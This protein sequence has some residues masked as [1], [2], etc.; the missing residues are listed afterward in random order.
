MRHAAFLRG[1]NVGGRRATGEQLCAPFEALGFSHVSSFL[2]SGNI[3][4]DT[5]A[6]VDD[7]EPRIEEALATALGFPVEAFV[8]TVTEVAGV[9]GQQ[10][11][12]AEVA[13]GSAGKPQ[14]T[15]LREAPSPTGMTAAL[16]LAT[17]QDRVAVIGRE[18]FWLPSDGISS[19][20]LD[21]RAMERAIGRGTTRTRA[22]VD[23]LHARMLRD[24]PAF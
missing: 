1:I 22:T 20:S 15:F 10:P 3:A 7:L 19:S 24:P 2:A 14:V 17:D 9:V 16:E 8:R 4:F 12:A 18:W 13:A 21:V 11:F 23:R 6:A 5:D